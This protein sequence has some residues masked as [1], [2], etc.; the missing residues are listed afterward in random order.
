MTT[1]DQWRQEHWPVNC[2]RCGRSSL[3]PIAYGKTIGPLPEGVK[4]GG[5]VVGYNA[6]AWSCT[7]CGLTGGSAYEEALLV[8]DELTPTDGPRRQRFQQMRERF[9]A[10]RAAHGQMPDARS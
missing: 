1:L 9:L 6:S 5:C 4:E 7:R 3:L 8:L 2:P 10:W